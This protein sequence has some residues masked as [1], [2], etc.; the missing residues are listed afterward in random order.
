MAANS[1]PPIRGL[2][3]SVR[4]IRGPTAVRGLPH[5]VR[6]IRG[7]T[8]SPPASPPGFERR[9]RPDSRR[10]CRSSWSGRPGGRAAPAPC[11]CR[12]RTPTDEWRMSDGTCGTWRASGSPT[13]SPPLAP[14]VAPPSRASDAAAALLSPCHGRPAS[15]ETRIATPILGWHAGTS[16]PPRGAS[17]PRRHRWRRSRSK[18]TLARFR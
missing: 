17:R 5:S 14:P 1:S 12:S 4:D 11:G 9:V 6:E 2:L 15:P 16:A 3:Y 18:R 7:P 13:R 8:T 10:G